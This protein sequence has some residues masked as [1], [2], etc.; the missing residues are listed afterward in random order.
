MDW[1]ARIMAL[2]RWALPVL[3]GGI[4]GAIALWRKRKTP[5]P[6]AV[7]PVV[8]AVPPAADPLPYGYA[9]GPSGQGNTY[10]GPSLTDVQTAIASAIGALPPPPDNTDELMSFASQISEQ[11]RQ[12][13]EQFSASI[14]AL[15]AAQTS[16]FAALAN[17][18]TLSRAAPVTAPAVPT[19]PPPVAPPPPV[20]AP[21]VAPP[22][23]IA[24]PTPVPT[25][26][27]DWQALAYF[28]GGKS[29]LMGGMHYAGEAVSFRWKEAPFYSQEPPPPSG[30][31]PVAI[32]PV[33]Y[34]GGHNTWRTGGEDAMSRTLR[35]A[36]NY[37]AGHPD[38]DIGTVWDGMLGRL[39]RDIG[40]WVSH[41]NEWYGTGFDL[42]SVR[43][44]PYLD[45][46][47]TPN[48]AWQNIY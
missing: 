41:Q 32:L 48:P 30:V 40:P 34:N 25:S 43:N 14:A 11:G 5:A 23:P 27:Q 7:A 4:A 1:K 37:K 20:V 29:G 22:A 9:F 17:A 3:A 15:S 38:A 12:Q 44:S 39:M 18:L 10:T 16:G 13:S 6:A 31:Y 8:A 33:N 36:A 2:P 46:N 42:G 21:P 19:P 35:W 24:S 47:G 45:G 26:G 28:L